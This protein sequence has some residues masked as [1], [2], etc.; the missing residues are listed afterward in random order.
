MKEQYRESDAARVIDNV[1]FG[2]MS[3]E[4]MKKQ[5]HIHIVNKG[6]YGQDSKAHVP[7]GVL[8]HRM[9]TSEKDNN[10]ETCKRGL[11]DCVGHYGYVDLEL[12]CFH[13]GYFRTCVTILQKICKTCSRI[14]L[15]DDVK[16]HYLEVL[17]RPG[18][19]YLHKKSLNKKINDK[20]KKMSICI[21]CGAKNGVVKK[22]GLLKIVHDKH[23][24]VGRNV[25]PCITDFLNS[26]EEVKKFNT[27]IENLLPKTQEMLNP[28]TVL[29]LFTAIPEED[30]PLLLMNISVS[31]PQD[32]LLTRLLVPPLCI[33]PS[34]VSDL[35]SGTN[36]DDITM[37]LTEIIFLNDVIQKHK[38]TNAKMQMIMEDW[39]FLQLQVTLLINSETSGIP[40][41]M[42]PKKSM[43]GFSQRLKGKQGRFRGNLSGKRVDF[44]GRTVI[45]PDP[46]MRIDQVAVP[47]HVAKI[48]TYPTKVTPS[49]IELMR[50]LIKN[51]PDVHPGANFLEQRQTSFK[52]FLK[53]GNKEKIAKEL[54]PGDC[55]ERHLMDGDVILFNRQPSLHKLSIQAFY[56]K[57]MP[58]RTF[59]FNECCCNPFNADFDGDE[60]NLHLPQTEEA[61]AE[62]ITLMGSKSNVITPRNGEPLIAAIQDFITAAYLITQKD[63][64]FDR[65]KACQLA[66]SLVV[67][68]VSKERLDLPPPCI[69]KPVKLWS[70]KQ[71]F[72]LVI[73]PSK[74]C[75][76]KANLRTKGKNYSSGEDMCHNDSFIV[77]HNSQLMCGAVD[78]G[79][80]GSGSKSQIFYQILRHFGEKQAADAMARLARL[81]PAYLTNRGFSIGIGDVTPGLGL[82]HA[83][84]N[85][86][87]NGYN[88]CNEYIQQLKEGSLT[89]QPGC[90]AEQTLE[91]V[92]LR[93]LSVIRDHA[94][95]ACLQELHPTNSPLTMAI[96]GSKGSF[97]NISQMIACVG[98]QAISGK[99]VPNGFE[100]RALPHFERH[101]K[102]PSAK[103]FVSNS[104]YSGLTPT[105]FFFH[106]MA[107]REGLVDTAVKTAETG[108]MQRRLVKSLEDLCCQ[109]DMTVR[110][111]I[112]E[113]VQFTF[114]G[115]SLDPVN[116]EGKDKPIDFQSLLA[117][118][119]A[120]HSEHNE[121]SLSG[122]SIREKSDEI[123]DSEEFKVCSED[124]REELRT[125]LHETGK[126]TSDTRQKLG[127]TE[128]KDVRSSGTK[129]LSQYEVKRLTSTQ[130]QIYLDVCRDKY[131]RALIEP[132][133]AVGAICAQSIG[134][135]GTQMTLKTF[136]FAGVASMNITLG[137]PRIKEIIN[138]A[139]AISTP[140]I[141]A[142][143]DVDDKQEF[144][145]VVKGRIEQTKLGEVSEYIE[146]VY[147]PDDCFLLIKLDMDRIALLKL[148]V[149]LNSICSS[150]VMSKLKIK[151]QH[152]DCHGDS[153]I[154]IKPCENSRSSMFYVMQHLK[155]YVPDVV[156]KGVPS[157][158]RAVIHIDETGGGVKY[159]LLVE[160]NNLRNVMAT[161]GVKATGTTSNNTYEVEKTL[162]IEAARL[163]IMNEITYTM[164]SHGMSIDV[165]HVMLLADLMTYKGEV[166]GIT[167]FGLAKMKESVLML[168]SFEKTADHLF[169]A[170]YFGQKDVIC[171]VSECIIM[172]IPMNVG[173]GLFKLLHS[174]DKTQP[175]SRPLVFDSLDLHLPEYS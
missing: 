1:T 113:I 154:C 2:L 44:S 61:K 109:Y 108:Y 128:D 166:L 99:R 52:R 126:K 173:T 116:M 51:G 153:I 174:V 86:L 32:L 163:T 175:V 102:T 136:H 49:N 46:N 118:V 4:Q 96:C 35:K 42:Q 137:V 81:C 80:L 168:A 50:K 100:D 134:E 164:R 78:K 87:T 73:R 165:R 79:T 13:I 62:A 63:V 36:E 3:A 103:G 47:V 55:I 114:G 159:K 48:L 125:F 45:S 91:A 127:L 146:E 20:T 10:C 139:K 106:T 34:V 141:S 82:L 75:N 162:G 135:P 58:H 77:I 17:K 93:E 88:K 155:Q 124:F 104:F 95:K 120:K 11:S 148:E 71:I 169:E 171:G 161:A 147:L 110:S 145:R 123:L 92:I 98:Q 115:D 22:C 122:D 143:L 56:A 142:T 15:T 18:M 26:F 21:R 119:C 157:V 167:R 85:L 84:E 117:H 8:D 69:V 111:S 107:G 105:E 40:Q 53:Y 37:K 101:C 132:G 28:L 59:R 83:K 6:L 41:N 112:G 149:D 151:P 68:S 121:L 12:P 65:A 33:R 150:L 25:H 131:M 38:A 160:G 158:S 156:I 67:G 43:R 5:S 74:S 39:D 130:L 152:L 89:T 66:A 172:G 31:H 72:S 27:E 140:I 129:A 19:S 7:Y 9:G 170:A 24:R 14:L 64:F 30:L 60:M 57:V 16:E 94:G 97:I 76:V 133:T 70:G 29:R 90:N 138:A 54:K 23:K 144:A